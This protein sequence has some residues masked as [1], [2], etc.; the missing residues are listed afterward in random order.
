MQVKPTITFDGQA[1][2]AI[3]FYQKVFNTTAEHVML[4]SD[5]PEGSKYQNLSEKNRGRVMNACIEVNG[6][7]LFGISDSMPD[8][9]PT[10]GN[11]LT[12]DIVFDEGD[13]RINTIFETLSEGG[14]VLVPLGETF[15]APKF[16]KI[17]DKFGIHW[18]VMQR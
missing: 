7:Y 16:G 17:I 15:F 6:D 8:C 3:Q 14:E 5:G 9:P 11:N 4:F 12:L 10:V 2:E 18:N 1:K 13:D